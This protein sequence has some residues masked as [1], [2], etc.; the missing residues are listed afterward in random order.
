M[1]TE[2]RKEIEEYILQKLEEIRFECEDAFD[3]T[4]MIHMTLSK[5]RSYFFAMDDDYEYVLRN[6]WKWNID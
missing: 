6:H 5:T 4:G 1:T 2:R 3:D